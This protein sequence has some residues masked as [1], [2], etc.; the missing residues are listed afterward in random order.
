MTVSGIQPSEA[1]ACQ[2]TMMIAGRIQPIHGLPYATPGR[3]IA[4]NSPGQTL[5]ASLSAMSVNAISRARPQ[6]IAALGVALPDPDNVPDMD[7]RRNQPE[8]LEAVG[9][10][11][12]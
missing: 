12:L 7:R 1:N 5:A 3:R 8:P 4:A 11:L 9:D 2:A 10:T 6:R